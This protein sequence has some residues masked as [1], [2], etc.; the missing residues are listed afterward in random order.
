MLTLYI[1]TVQHSRYGEADGKKIYVFIPRSFLVVNV[2]NQGKNLCSSC[3][4]TQYSTVDTEKLM[5]KIIHLLWNCVY[6]R[7]SL[8]HNLLDEFH[9][10]SFC[11]KL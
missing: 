9:P 8:L 3:I 5:E 4:F 2:C 7:R 11:F 10:C 6:N 1:H